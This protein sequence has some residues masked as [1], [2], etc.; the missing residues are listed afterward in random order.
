MIL[1]I[2]T[3][4]NNLVVI[5]IKNKDRFIAKKKFVSNRTQAEKLLPSI[6]KM[7]KVNKLKL[8]DLESIEVANRGGSFTSLRI[9]VVTANALGYALSI[10]VSREG[11]KVKKS[12]GG[13][14]KFNPVRPEYDSEPEIIAKKA[15]N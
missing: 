9:G 6:D 15:R 4:A 1:Y 12:K 3:T 13:K 7:L 2:N 10:P 5:G 8:S 11:R 14:L